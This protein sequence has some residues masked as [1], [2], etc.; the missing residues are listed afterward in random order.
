[1]TSLLCLIF[2]HSKMITVPGWD[3]CCNPLM[4]KQNLQLGWGSF[5]PSMGLETICGA[6]GEVKIMERNA[7][8]QRFPTKPA[9]PTDTKDEKSC[10]FF[11]TKNI[12]QEVSTLPKYLVLV[13]DAPES[14]NW[15]ANLLSAIR[16]RQNEKK[17]L[18]K[19]H[20]IEKEWPPSFC[21]KFN[22]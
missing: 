18:G 22:A 10:G 14:F 12:S 16:A 1:M 9:A 7:T 6:E 4:P 17:H 11:Y 3:F 15:E 2:H 21:M 19:G 8:Q 5:P 13:K 20:C